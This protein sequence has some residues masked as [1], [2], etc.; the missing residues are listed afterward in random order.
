MSAPNDY[1]EESVSAILSKM[2]GSGTLEA[3]NTNESLP[4]SS[5]EQENRNSAVE[6][7]G[8]AA[9]LQKQDSI[10][11]TSP[12]TGDQQEDSS[13]IRTAQSKSKEIPEES[14]GADFEYPNIICVLLE[15][16]VDPQLIRFL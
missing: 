11:T 10:K 12:G 2:Q 8:A 4:V 7:A 16:F 1:S 13:K 15:S 3:D 5:K 9:S 6:E 14:A